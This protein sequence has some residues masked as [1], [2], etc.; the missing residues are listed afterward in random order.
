MYKETKVLFGVQV[1]VSGSCERYD[2]IRYVGQCFESG[3]FVPDPGCLFRVPDPTLFHP[4][5][6]IRIFSSQ[7]RINEFKYFEPRKLVFKLLEI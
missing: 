7:I 2:K 6:R 1:T 3:M 4:G 5:S